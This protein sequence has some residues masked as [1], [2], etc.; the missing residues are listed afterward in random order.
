MKSIIVTSIVALVALLS[1]CSDEGLIVKG[2]GSIITE[3]RTVSNFNAIEL[4]NNADVEV[5]KGDQLAVEVSD[6]ENII[7]YIEVYVNNN[8]LMIRKKMVFGFVIHMPK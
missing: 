7:E 8:V 3:N 4:Q 1:S 2:K 5:V 6:Y